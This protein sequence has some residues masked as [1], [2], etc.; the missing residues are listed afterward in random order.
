M[1]M[2]PPVTLP[3]PSI[4]AKSEESIQDS[5]VPKT[6]RMDLAISRHVISPLRQPP[7]TI[8]HCGSRA[9]PAIFRFG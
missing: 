6:W 4:T 2:H 3:L 1:G 7:I 5:K 8:N 9:R